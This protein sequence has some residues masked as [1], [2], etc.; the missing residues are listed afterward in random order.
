MRTL[1]VLEETGRTLGSFD[2]P[3]GKVCPGSVEKLVLSLHDGNAVEAILIG[4]FGPRVNIALELDDLIHKKVGIRPASYS[5][6]IQ[7]KIAYDTCVS[8]QVGCAL[9]C[10]FCASSVVPFV[11]NLTADEILGEIATIET[12]IPRGGK[13][14]KVLFAGVGEPLMNYDNV[15]KVARTLKR[16]GIAVKVNTVGVLPYLE[17]LFSDRLECDL[18]VSIHAPNDE[19]RAQ[20]MPAGKGYKLGQICAMLKKAPSSIRFLEA[21]YIMLEEINDSLEHARELVELM[22]GLPLTVCLQIYNHIE[23]FDYTPSPPTQVVRFARTLRDG[24]LT[25]DIL[26]SN[27]G[28]DVVGGCGQLRARVEQKKASRLAIVD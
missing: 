16:R 25:V 23:E 2:T 12:R 9:D 13:L 5:K 6:L 1:P 18:A 8:T 3:E 19:L 21:K 4:H 24:G 15:A 22:R 14:R 28:E 26:N 17:R 27:L 10:K 20:L 11:R 7:R